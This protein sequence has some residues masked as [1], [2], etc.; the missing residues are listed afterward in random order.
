[1]NAEQAAAKAQER[2]WQLAMEEHAN[3]AISGAF[4]HARATGLPVRLEPPLG[5]RP[6]VGVIGPDGAWNSFYV[7]LTPVVNR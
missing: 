5:G 2:A 3:A 7:R 6:V 4:T 1:M